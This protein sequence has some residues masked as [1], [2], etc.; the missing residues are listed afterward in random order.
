NLVFTGVDDDPGTVETLSNL[1]FSEPDRVIE[2][3]RLWHRGRTPATRTARGRELLTAL[4]P[5]L[6][7]AMGKTGQPDEAFKRFSRFFE[8][9]RSG[10]QTLSMLLA[11]PEL[12]EDLVTT[13]ALAPRIGGELSRRPGLLEALLSV[14]D[15]KDAPNLT[16]ETD[17]ETAMNL[18]RRWHGEHAFIIGHR[19]LHGKIAARDAAAAWSALADETVSLMA[20]VAERETIRRYGDP[21]GPWCVAGLGKF[22]GQEMTAGSDL[23]LLV[24]YDAEDALE[25]QTWLTRFTQRLITA[26]SAETGEGA[27]YEVD[28][29]LRPSGRAGPVATSLSAF[30]RY[31]TESAWTWEHMALTRLRVVTGDNDLGRQVETHAT[32]HI[33][34]SGEANTRTKDIL[35]MRA[36]L[37][38]D[39]PASGEW[40]LKMRPGGLVDIE[41]IVQ[42]GLL[43]TGTPIALPL[44]VEDAIETLHTSGALNADQASLL[45]NARTFLSALQQVQR[46]AIG[47]KMDAETLSDVLIDRLCRATGCKNFSDLKQT[48]ERYCSAVSALFSEK[49]GPLPT[50][51]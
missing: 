49:V 3:I 14:T 10:V 29:R 23:D 43:T 27:L 42:H 37:R 38:R 9:L 16:P 26:L 19:L 6:L 8:G 1:G 4:L 11:E 39:K 41:F 34:E 40:D 32:R 47:T 28:M 45:L 44:S 24:L 48:L 30:N 51:S 18:V 13:L 22:G 36:R 12:M 33:I 17:F 7:T 31:H 2:S 50:D 20:S 35:D 15:R 5:D 25:A 46:V 21:P